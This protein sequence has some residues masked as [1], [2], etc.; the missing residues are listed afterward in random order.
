VVTY[1]AVLRVANN[2]LALRPGMT[3]TARIVVKDIKQALTVPNSAFRYAPP[4]QEEAQGFSLTNIFIPRMPRFQRSTNNA[5]PNGERI[6]WI[7]DNGVPKDI[8]VKTGAS[9]GQ[10]TEI[11]SGDITAGAEVII[12]SRQGTAP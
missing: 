8:R 9:D 12:A 10:F 1:N 4:K 2:D 6:L 7:L 3:A 11:L 5:A